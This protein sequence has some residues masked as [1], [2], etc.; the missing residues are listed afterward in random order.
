[1]KYSFLRSKAIPPSV[2]VKG[3]KLIIQLQDTLIPNTTYV[4][5]VGTGIK[6]ATEGNDM[7]SPIIFAFSTGN[8]LDSLSIKGRITEPKTGIGLKDMTVL[9]YPEN[10]IV[11]DS[12]FDVKPIYA[13]ITDENGNFGLYYL[14]RQKYKIYGVLDVDKSYSYNQITE[15]I[16][17][18]DD[19]S[20]VFPDSEFVVTKDLFLFLPDQKGPV[21]RGIAFANT[22]TVSVDFREKI[23]EGFNGDSLQI[24]IS[25]TLGE[26]RQEITDFTFVR[27]NPN[28]LIFPFQQVEDQAYNI[29]FVNLFDTLGNQSDTIARLYSDAIEKEFKSVLLFSPYV[30]LDPPSVNI[31]TTWQVSDNQ[32]DTMISIRDTF[33]NYLTSNWKVNGHT[34][35]LYPDSFPKDKSRP[36]NLLLM[37]GLLF[38]NDSISDSTFTF[39]LTFPNLTQA[40]N[41]E[42]I[43]RRFCLSWKLDR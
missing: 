8:Q 37:N 41:T 23:R 22:S 42:R 38:K 1:M 5:T 39:P 35:S 17:L 4:V 33:G 11:G 29:E 19:Q 13:S 31:Q 30:Q 2:I 6:D 28:Y 14:S 26:N 7:A 36:Y 27:E 40:G 32:L 24:F 12:I 16:A 18:T 20:V 43:C 25:D 34:V 10:Q 21:P 3:K 15:A 9:L